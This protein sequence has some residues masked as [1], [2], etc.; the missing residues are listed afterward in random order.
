MEAS[1]SGIGV[2]GVGKF[3]LSVLLKCCVYWRLEVLEVHLLQQLDLFFANTNH[4][5]REFNVSCALCSFTDLFIHCT[6][7]KHLQHLDE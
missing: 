3:F 1:L 6:L 5:H 7:H 4:Y 2:I